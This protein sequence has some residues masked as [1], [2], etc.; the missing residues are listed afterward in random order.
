[1]CDP[2]VT[3]RNLR[4]RSLSA[5]GKI[6]AIYLYKTPRLEIR[7]YFA[8]SFCN[9]MIVLEHAKNMCR[10]AYD[11]YKHRLIFIQHSHWETTLHSV[12]AMCYFC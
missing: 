6:D 2:S 3:V 9:G 12:N 4:V 10:A 5:T 8:T 7:Q 11:H 1:M